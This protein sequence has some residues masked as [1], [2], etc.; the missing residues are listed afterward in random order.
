MPWPQP[1]LHISLQDLSVFLTDF[2]GPHV[3]HAC[4]PYTPGPL[5][6]PDRLLKGPH[7]QGQGLGLGLGPLTLTP[8][9]I[10]PNCNPNP[11]WSI[12]YIFLTL[13]RTFSPTVFS[14][15]VSA[16]Y[17]AWIIYVIL[18]NPDPNPYLF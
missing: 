12:N 4:P 3:W 10:Y 5:G 17:D 8:S 13:I 11:S 6:V 2:S 18:A 1:P 16:Y 9:P 7:D 14:K 15:L